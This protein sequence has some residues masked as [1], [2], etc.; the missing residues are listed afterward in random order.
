MDRLNEAQSN[1]LKVLLGME[2]VFFDG[3]DGSGSMWTLR[4]DYQARWNQYLN[5][6]KT[7]GLDLKGKNSPLLGFYFEEAFW[8]Q[9][10]AKSEKEIKTNW[11]LMSHNLEVIAKTI[12]LDFPKAIVALS[13][14]SY[15]GLVQSDLKGGATTNFCPQC[16]SSIVIPKEIDWI[17]LEGLY[18]EKM[19]STASVNDCP[20]WNSCYSKSIPQHFNDLKTKLRFPNQKTF[21]VPPTNLYSSILN[22]H[23]PQ[24]V[25]TISN[26]RGAIVKAYTQLAAQDLS[27]VAVIG[28]HWQN[29][30]I[31]GRT[32]N[33]IGVSTN[34]LVNPPSAK[35]IA[36]MDNLL[37]SSRLIQVNLVITNQLMNAQ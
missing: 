34:P 30:V 36:P 29:S 18:A 31:T 1:G 10:L 37:K 5:Q 15:G 22:N 7:L 8:Q 26:D 9:T 6:Y 28:Y 35:L 17:G 14:L 16:A 4:S 33:E 2:A 12:K 27:V 23:D 21:L 25:S 11:A 20:A 3:H 13:D 19:I 32:W 24:Q